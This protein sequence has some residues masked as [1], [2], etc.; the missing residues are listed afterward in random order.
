MEL[1]PWC[2]FWFLVQQHLKHVIK[3]V[4]SNH[5]VTVLWFYVIIIN[6]H[7]MFF[8]LPAFGFPWTYY[9]SVVTQQWLALSPPF[10]SGICSALITSK[11]QSTS[12]KL[13]HFFRL[14]IVRLYHLSF[15]TK[16]SQ[17]R[18]TPAVI[19][20]IVK[21]FS[22]SF[23]PF[24]HELVSLTTLWIKTPDVPKD[25]SVFETQTY[26]SLSVCWSVRWWRACWDCWGLSVWQERCQLWR[27]WLIFCDKAQ[28]Q[29]RLYAKRRH[30]V[31]C[32]KVL[33]CVGFFIVCWISFIKT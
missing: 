14:G 11:L 21:S 3:K 10:D 20:T 32:T 6:V 33:R 19:I 2:S 24:P 26:P 22:N 30:I 18:P 9:S 28:Q 29:Q 15:L 16:K 7:I 12:V 31:T 25:C 13:E 17:P 4:R 23:L 27:E 8:W 1:L 5:L